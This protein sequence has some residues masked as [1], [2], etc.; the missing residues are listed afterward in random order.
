[1]R[2]QAFRFISNIHLKFV[3]EHV[4]DIEFARFLLRHGANPNLKSVFGDTPLH[5][6]VTSASIECMKLLCDHGADP[7]ISE[8]FSDLTP[9]SMSQCHIEA[10]T[11]MNNA[12]RKLESN[13][14]TLPH[15]D[16]S[17]CKV[18]GVSSKI[19]KLFQW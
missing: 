10:M 4:L 14:S 6:C 16:V 5:S 13:V 15:E 17:Y 8:E 12:V 11:I 18:C 3:N 19:K 1:M 2:N 9:L 7:R